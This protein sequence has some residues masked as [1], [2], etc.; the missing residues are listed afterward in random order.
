MPSNNKKETALARATA[1]VPTASPDQKV[2]DV[3][4][5]IRRKRTWDF[6]YYIYIVNG[7]GLVETPAYCKLFYTIGQEM[8]GPRV[9]SGKIEIGFR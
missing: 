6:P 5:K 4:A 2:S 7:R 9:I 8:T 3:L 1:N